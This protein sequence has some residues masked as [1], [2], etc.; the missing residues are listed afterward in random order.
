M[1]FEENG[2]GIG[3]TMLVG[4][5]ATGNTGYPYPV[6]MNGGSG[7]GNGGFGGDGW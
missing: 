1:A 5:T 2:S 7:F 3:A 4:P 6:Y